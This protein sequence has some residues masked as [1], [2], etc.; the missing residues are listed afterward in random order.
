[1]TPKGAKSFSA[2]LWENFV[3]LPAPHW[4]SLRTV[5]VEASWE[6]PFCTDKKRRFRRPEHL[7]RSALS[8]REGQ[9]N[10]PSRD[11]SDREGS[12]LRS[13]PVKIHPSYRCA[14]PEPSR[15]SERH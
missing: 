1:M 8:S 12:A 2:H 4:N 10:S 7:G 6:F 15:S 9:E 11:R 3:N 13:V 14:L 5:Q